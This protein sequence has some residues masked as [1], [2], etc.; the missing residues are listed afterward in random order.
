A[1]SG[2]INRPRM[3]FLYVLPVAAENLS[4]ALNYFATV[5]VDYI[6][7]PCDCSAAD[8]AEVAAWVAARRADDMAVKAVLPSKA[9][10]NEGVINFT[11]AGIKTGETAFTTA[12]YCSRIAGMLAGTP[13]NIACTYAILP[14]VTD[15]T[16]LSTAES[17]AAIDRGELILY[18]DGEKVKIA[19]GVNSLQTTTADKGAAFKK[20]KI[21]EAT[22]VMRRDITRAVQDSYIGKYQNSYDNKCLLIS[23]IQ[24]YL[25]AMEQQGVLAAGKS[26]VGINMTQQRQ[27][28]TA[29]GMDVSRMTEQEIKSADTGEQVFLTATVKILDAIEDIDLAIII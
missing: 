1:F 14:E 5:D 28:L 18:H 6:T 7:A 9:A 29:H 2:Y 10:D 19:R 4:P 25:Q 16:R 13:L 20:I 17:T 15:I 11:A 8:A 3:V 26:S 23:A 22:D 21:V 27:Y 12:Q 24:S